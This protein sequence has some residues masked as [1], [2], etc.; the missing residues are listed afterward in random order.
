MH[1]RCASLTTLLATPALFIFSASLTVRAADLSSPV[2]AP[3]PALFEGIEF[4]VHA[5]AGITGN[6]ANPA[7]GQN[8]GQIF[9]DRANKPLLNQIFGTL[10]KPINVDVPDYQFGFK[11]Q[12]LYGSDARYEQFIGLNQNLLKTENQ[13]ALYNAY[14]IV[15]LPWLFARGIDVK[16][17]ITSSLE[18][19][20]S[21]DALNTPFYSRSYAYNYS[22]D[23]N[24]LGILTISH[25][26]KDFD[27]YLGVDTGNQTTFNGVNNHG[28]AGQGGFKFRNLLNGK[29]DVLAF[30]QIGHEDNSR[31]D[32][33]SN[34]DLREYNAVDFIYR[35][36]D[37]LTSVTE[38]NGIH[39]SKVIGTR[40]DGSTAY[41]V[42][43]YLFYKLNSTM[44]LN[45]RAEIFRDAD[46]NFVGNDP[47]NNDAVNA[48]QGLPNTTFG[49]S[50]PTTYSELALALV[51]KP[52]V[53]APLIVQLR[54]EVRYDRALSGGLPFNPTVANV[55]TSRDQFTFGGDVVIGF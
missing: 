41:G 17:G 13:V 48:K 19:Y 53:P 35:I 49:L 31:T 16:V 32:P 15:H 4:H 26:T 11:I 23:G 55:G 1:G 20:E 30:T 10:E 54:P 34:N 9:T 36:N 22:E 38:P 45:A 50:V 46:G 12:G 37:S 47:G 33:N 28:P 8:V 43:Q 52:V 6:A 40:T 3:L 25:V 42:V 29:L 51:F 39:E 21:L 24:H 2:A 44:T 14:G 7:D 18:G 5:E 27:L